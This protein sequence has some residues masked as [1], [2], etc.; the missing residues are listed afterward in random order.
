MLVGLR[1][2]IPFAYSA[3]NYGIPVKQHSGKRKISTQA[4]FAVPALGRRSPRRSMA[5]CLQELDAMGFEALE[6]R[7]QLVCILAHRDLGL[8]LLKR[9]LS[10]QA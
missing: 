1:I 9:T 5:R 4:V 2:R 8:A 7:P 10:G 6:Q 3:Q